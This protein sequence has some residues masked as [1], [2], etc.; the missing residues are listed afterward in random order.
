MG[1][2]GFEGRHYSLFES[3]TGDFAEAASVQALLTA[4]AFKYVA[5]GTVTHED[6]PD[7]PATES[8]RRQFLFAAALGVQTC[9]VRHDSANRFMMKILAK[10]KKT[11]AS[12]RYPGY[13]RVR[14]PDYCRALVAALEEDAADLIE[15]LQLTETVDLLRRRL[16][17]PQEYAA[18]GKLTT[19]IL[20]ETGARSPLKLS[21]N[22]FN[23]AAEHYYRE[24]LRRRHME[25]AVQS[26][27]NNLRDIDRDQPADHR[28]R[29]I[30][31][32][33]IGTGSAR[34]FFE[35]RKAG[36]LA[37][38]LDERTLAQCIQLTLLAI[39]RDRDLA[40]PDA[41]TASVCP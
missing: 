25:E 27:L 17:E 30:A 8:E 20:E 10:T 2:S 3:L 41:A 23:L 21:G 15:S 29:A 38:T 31:S 12:R 22:E 34:D 6:I 24:T 14:L 1:F 4:L 28:Y 16:R 37:E 13:L 5:E 39:Q 9:S 18:S 19:G 35:A 7:D 33:I 32:Q 26:L 36:L 40:A 11:R